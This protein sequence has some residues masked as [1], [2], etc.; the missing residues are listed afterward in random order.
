MWTDDLQALRCDASSGPCPA[1]L[2][3]FGRSAKVYESGAIVSR[4]DG[5]LQQYVDVWAGWWM[6]GC[7]YICTLRPGGVM[8]MNVIENAEA[9]A[10]HVRIAMHL[11]GGQ[12]GDSRN[13]SKLL[14]LC[15]AP[16]GRWD[17]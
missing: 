17:R 7:I 13:G 15:P 11:W 10:S 1:R 6:G 12:R 4:D 2:L 14:L 16:G 9:L 8:T 3:S 5:E